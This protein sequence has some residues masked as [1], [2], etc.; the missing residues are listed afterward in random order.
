MKLQ[1]FVHRTCVIIPLSNSVMVCGARG[2][3]V[4]WAGYFQHVVLHTIIKYS[5][6]YGWEN[7]WTEGIL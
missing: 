1:D 4:P 7:L 3:R 2:P 5:I 6:Q